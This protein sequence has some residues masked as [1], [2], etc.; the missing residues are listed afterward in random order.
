M[1]Q[2]AVVQVEEVQAGTGLIWI[3]ARTRD[4]IAVLCPGCGWSSDWVHSRY[5]RHLADEAVGGR[6]VVI[7]LS[8]RRL[9]CENPACPKATFVEQAQGLTVRYQRRTPAL[10][11]VL[12]AVAVAL[13][14]KA[15]ARLLVHLHQA[16]S[17]STMLHCLMSLPDPPTP[18][19]AVLGVDDFA[20]L[21]GQ[22]YGTLL[23]D[24]LTR[25]PIDLFAGRT[26]GA[27]A[28]WL[29]AHPGIGT[30][31]RDGALV[32][33]NGITAGAP[34]A[35]QVSDRFHLWQGLARKVDEAVSAHRAC[36]TPPPQAA[37]A[38]APTPQD[39]QADTD[40][41]LPIPAEPTGRAADRARATHTAVHTLL[42][43][44]LSSRTIA[45]QSGLSRSTVQRYARVARWQD[46][47][48]VWP[49]QPTILDP[50]RAYLQQRWDQGQRRITALHREITTRGFTGSYGTVRD[51]LNP[52][53]T[54]ARRGPQ[55]EPPPVP[56]STRE[57]TGWITRRPEN[58]TEDQQVKLKA[59]LSRC[60]E[61][62]AVHGHVRSFGSMLT[63]GS[64]AGLD[65]WIAAVRTSSL[66]ALPG[67]ARG[68]AGDLDAVRAG[69]SLSYN[70]GVNEGRVT[71]L[72][73]I[74]RQM[75]GRAGIPLLRK[76]VILVAHS[77]RTT[78]INPTNDDPWTIN[79]YETLV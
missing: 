31:C 39:P 18:T 11:R 37:P 58:L 51:F 12:D 63:S 6:P 27:L 36:L 5:V 53:R 44:G 41:T 17:W 71:D 66:P 75:G 21:R 25:L 60:P 20:L 70:S 49:R 59:V 43:Q 57:M 61:L 9:Y 46:K 24:T 26:S 32:Y 74:K 28:D 34:N 42:D 50:H 30:V 15:G 55:A 10:Q 69:L 73:L 72:K 64:A 65:E 67:F 1:P 2:L 62:D 76:R 47:V 56:P 78:T 52:L 79:A 29:L 54:A 16:V 4:D 23:V 38:P 22:N 35:V 45:K 40:T 19:P 33:R 3:T 13:A 7:D 68:L 77:R 48:P 8:V 14:G